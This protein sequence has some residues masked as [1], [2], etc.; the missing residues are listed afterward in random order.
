MTRK[1]AVTEE[2]SYR[3]ED[4]R[5]CGSEA[6]IGDVPDDVVEPLGFAVVLGEGDFDREREDEGNWDEEFRFAAAK[7][8]TRLPTVEGYVVCEECAQAVHDHSTESGSYTGTIPSELVPAVKS[9][10][11]G[12]GASADTGFDETLAYL[13]IGAVVI[14]AIIFL[15]L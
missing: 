1:S 2:I 9:R 12:S 3:T 8:E 15:L 7:E 5:V 11:S 13:V 14:L 10:G 6:A 4:C